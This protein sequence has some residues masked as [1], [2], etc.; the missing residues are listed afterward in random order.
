MER[1]ENTKHRINSLCKT[2]RMINLRIRVV[3][4]RYVPDLHDFQ[5]AEVSSVTIFVTFR[6]LEHNRALTQFID[7]L[8]RL[9]ISYYART[10]YNFL[11]F[12]LI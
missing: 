1:N 5:L 3:F 2:I 10:F 8:L 9:T 12:D 4:S 11:S 6:S 7:C